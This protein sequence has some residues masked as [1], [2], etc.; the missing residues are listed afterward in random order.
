MSKK[1][2]SVKSHFRRLRDIRTGQ[3]TNHDKG[4][5][6]HIA[7]IVLDKQYLKGE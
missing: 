5:S 1:N 2:N 4:H 3:I 7:C 6:H